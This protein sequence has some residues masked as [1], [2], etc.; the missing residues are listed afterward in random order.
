MSSLQTCLHP[1]RFCSMTALP[2]RHAE[3]GVFGLFFL[4]STNILPLPMFL[5]LALEADP[6]FHVVQTQCF[7]GCQGLCVTRRLGSVCILDHKGT[8]NAAQNVYGIFRPRQICS[9]LQFEHPGEMPSTAGNH[10]HLHSEGALPASNRPK[11]TFLN[12]SEGP[13][14]TVLW[15]K[16]LQTPARE[17]RCCEML[18]HGSAMG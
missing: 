18:V 2:A 7:F 4:P 15:Q 1:S 16:S 8:E 12:H 5:S 13:Y 10:Q 9:M 14:K 17:G 3:P 11:R 6:A